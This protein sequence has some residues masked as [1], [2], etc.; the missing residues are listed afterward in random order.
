MLD[1]FIKYVMYYNIMLYMLRTKLT[2]AF[3]NKRYKFITF[4]IQ[5]I[6]HL[7]NNDSNDNI[8][9]NEGMIPDI[10][11]SLYFSQ[12]QSIRC[13]EFDCDVLKKILS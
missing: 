7:K 4:N 2:L 1:K 9:L 3:R 13:G 5:R 6:C 10:S 11:I 12:E 8:F